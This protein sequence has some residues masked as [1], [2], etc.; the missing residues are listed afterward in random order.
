MK[1]N[2]DSDAFDET[3]RRTGPFRSISSP[4]WTQMEKQTLE[5]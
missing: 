2:D 5:K 1:R 4:G 3:E